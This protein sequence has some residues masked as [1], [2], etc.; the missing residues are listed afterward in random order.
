MLPD[1]QASAPSSHG[2][3]N[4]EDQQNVEIVLSEGFIL[5]P[6]FGKGSLNVGWH[7]VITIINDWFILLLLLLLLLL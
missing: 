3:K 6:A 4:G 5:C 2:G 7:I 1:S